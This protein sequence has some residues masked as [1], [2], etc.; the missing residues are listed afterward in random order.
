MCHVKADSI[1]G[2]RSVSQPSLIEE[3]FEENSANSRFL[4]PSERRLLPHEGVMRTLI[5]RVTDG[6]GREPITDGRRQSDQWFGTH[7]LTLAGNLNSMV[8]IL[9]QI[10]DFIPHPSSFFRSH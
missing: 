7:D 6:E 5:I 4:I 8:R 1:R 3:N 10:K 9:L 2:A